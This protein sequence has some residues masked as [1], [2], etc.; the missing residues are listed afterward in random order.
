MTVG[1]VEHSH[2]GL[3]KEFVESPCLEIIPKW[4]AHSSELRGLV[5]PTWNKDVKLDDLLWSLS[6]P[7]IL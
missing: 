6:T 2:N 1:V 5:D 3:L 4:T 7:V